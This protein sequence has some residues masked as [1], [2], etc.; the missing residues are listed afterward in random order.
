M[1]DWVRSL[2]EAGTGKLVGDHKAPTNHIAPYGIV[3]TIDGGMEWG[4]PL[5]APESEAIFVYQVTS[6]GA[7]RDQAEWMADRVRRTMIDR[8]P[9]GS[10]LVI[11]NPPPAGS[12]VQDRRPQGAR[13][14]AEE[15]GDVWQVAERYEICVGG[16]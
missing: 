13:G 10:F 2:L 11:G 7:R 9:D 8:A 5:T 6:V 4:A 1:T 15:Q 12:V 14:M 3:Y 16:A